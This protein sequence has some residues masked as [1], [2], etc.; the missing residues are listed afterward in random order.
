MNLK[1]NLS[2][3]LLKVPSPLLRTKLNVDHAGLSL[4][5]VVSKDST[6]EKLVNYYLS[7]NKLWLTAL[8][9]EIWVAAVDSWTGHSP[10][11]KI[12]VS[13]LNPITLTLPLME[14][15]KHFN[16]NCLSQDLLMFLN[17]NL[18]K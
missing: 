9:A 13:H 6:S 5:L 7:L 1:L 16:L 2:I 3:G 15:V 11:L 10:M 14:H 4:L 17:P 12:T 8:M 18:V